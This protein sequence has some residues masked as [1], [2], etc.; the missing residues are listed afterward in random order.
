MYKVLETGTNMLF[1]IIF[2]IELLIPKTPTIE[3]GWE[4]IE[5]WDSPLLTT[6]VFIKYGNLRMNKKTLACYTHFG[7]IEYQKTTIKNEIR[8]LSEL[9]NFYS[10]FLIKYLG[11]NEGDTSIS[12]YTEGYN[13]LNSLTVDV[14]DITTLMDFLLKTIKV[15]H[16]NNV[17]HGDIAI[18]NIGYSTDNGGY[19]INTVESQIDLKLINFQ[20]ASIKEELKATYSGDLNNAAPEVY[21]V[22]L[23]KAGQY[24]TKAADMYTVGVLL[25]QY[26]VYTN[27]ISKTSIDINK[28]IKSSNYNRFRLYKLY[29]CYSNRKMIFKKKNNNRNKMVAIIQGLTRCNPEKRV[30]IDQALELFKQYRKDTATN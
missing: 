6:Q 17:V 28:R 8:V 23:S 29:N 7:S 24:N 22:L 11:W 10:L 26:Y 15:L 27:D 16:D 25:G 19:S 13:L 20:H 1:F 3:E 4:A 2:A 30:T 12:I 14:V 21:E 9:N 18:S 5:S